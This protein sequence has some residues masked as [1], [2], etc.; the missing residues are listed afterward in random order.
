MLSHANRSLQTYP[1]DFVEPE[2][3]PPIHLKTHIKKALPVSLNDESAKSPRGLQR[4]IP[5]Q[6]LPALPST[7]C[8]RHSLPRPSVVAYLPTSM[9]SCPLPST[10][11]SRRSLTSPSLDSFGSSLRRSKSFHTILSN[12]GFASNPLDNTH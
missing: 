7:I 10:A 12:R 3:L 1:D 9:Q 4:A 8:S 6:L 2:G 11:R 5:R